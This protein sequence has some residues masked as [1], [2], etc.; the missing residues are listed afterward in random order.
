MIRLKSLTLRRGTKVLLNR[1]ELTL[2]PG[3]KTGIVG[4]NGA[5]KSSFFAL[6]RDEIHADEGDLEMPPRVA[7]AH[8]AQETPALP[9]S[10]LDYV[11][12]GDVE[13][14]KIEAEINA[15]GA[16]DHDGMTH[17]E[18]YARLDAIDGYTAPA[19]AAKLL[20][21]LG[22]SLE[23]NTKPV[24]SFSGGWRMRLNL[25]QA[26]MCR[27][28]LL[29]LD[30]PTN[31]LDLETVVWLEEWLKSYQGMLLIISH[32]R[33][34][35]NS[36]VKQILHVD[37]AQLTVYTGT[38]EDFENQCAE[39]LAQQAQAF[40][41]QQRQIA[42]LESFITRF[43]AKASKAK[44]AQSRVKT[45]E[46]MEKIAAA[47]VDSPFSFS[48]REPDSSPN[49][50]VHLEKAAAGYSIDKPILTQMNLSIDNSA[51]LGL[52]G[53]NGAGKSTFIRALAGE[54]ALLS[55]IRT[56]GKGL[57]IGYF[58]QH[59][60]E[61][62]RIDESP[63]WHMQKIDPTARE[64][65][66]RNFLGGFNFQGPMALSP[67]APFSGGE[68]ARL[69]LAL[70][71]WQK[72]NLLLLDEPTNHLDIEMREALTFA[73][74]DFNGALIV[75]SHDR[76]ILRATVDDFW[77]IE[78]GRIAPFDGD[79]DDYARYS[80]EK[81]SVDK[82]AAN[83]MQAVNQVATSINRKEQKRLEADAR[84][85]LANARKPLEKQ[86]AR[87]EAEMARI[88][89]E[90]NAITASLAEESL[91]SPARKEDLQKILANE[92]QLKEKMAEQETAWMILSNEIE[93][94][95]F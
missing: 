42:H 58:A 15:I 20:A 35:L 92:L 63:L 22:F 54:Q 84:Q 49:P 36:T 48:F 57:K 38:Y 25:A 31:H 34:F 66:L 33:D 23:E 61:Y 21:G 14:R 56:E 75:V 13:L 77:L 51:R 16:D 86:L 9:C 17:G 43:K 32:D 19:R 39:R 11:L 47:H 65:E 89:L 6:L 2:Q 7:I 72:P 27:S 90:Q 5:G 4:A 26:L 83:A 68:K 41:K 3:S 24:S 40:D 69:A 8:V 30:E 10:A 46:K 55:G 37:N 71:I 44:Q 52:L 64:Q 91:Y 74:Q 59:Q 95:V 67:I 50:L 70:L 85:K 78:D 73:L 18:L 45:L 1:V 76:H 93:N 79:L 94:L 53:V 88:S 80:Q 81:R 62:L 12:D 28:D 60:L 87:I 82:S 29:L